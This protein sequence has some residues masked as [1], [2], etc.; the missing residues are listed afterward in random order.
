[1]VSLVDVARRANV[2]LTTASRVLSSSQHPVSGEK[3]TRVLRA[4]RELNYTPSVLAQAMVT[5]DT[6]IIGVI[7]G[8]AADPYF[9]SIV[10][11]IEDIARANHYLVIICNSDRD[12][13][14]ELSY[15]HTLNGYRVDGVIFA[16]GGLNDPDYLQGMDFFLKNFYDR[17]AA[18]ISLGKHLFPNYSVL[19]DFKQLVE[20]AVDYLANLGHKKIA[21]ISGPSQLTTTDD[22]FKGFCSGLEKHSIRV[23]QDY[24]LDGDFTYESGIRAIELILAMGERPT[25]I[26]ASN[27]LMAVGCIAALKEAGLR[28]PE[29]FSVMGIDDI[30]FA[31]FIDPPLT[32]ISIP[33]YLLGKIGME[34]LLQIRR[35]ELAGQGE[36]VLPHKLIVRASTGRPPGISLP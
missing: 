3:R 5:G 11:G 12:S 24:L 30:P 28:I 4:A 36:L 23:N 33:L 6:H 35:G 26:L 7:V 17:G 29:Q 32:T 2:S 25:A 27:D 19:V 18:C 20:D 16:G 13:E 34:R 21:Y 22:R 8:D 31:R 1:M 14:A 15:L 10:R 9:A